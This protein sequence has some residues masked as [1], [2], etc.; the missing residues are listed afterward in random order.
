MFSLF[1]RPFEK[2]TLESWSKMCDDVAKVAILAEPVVIWGNAD[3][4]TK[5]V[6]GILLLIA[7]YLFLSLGRKLKQAKLDLEGE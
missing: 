6:N 5:M 4:I 1:K 7:I 2:E 3:V